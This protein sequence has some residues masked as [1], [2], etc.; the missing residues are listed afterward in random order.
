[1][2]SIPL[3]ELGDLVNETIEEM[4]QIAE[5]Y[6]LAVND[7]FVTVLNP[8]AVDEWK[9]LAK[10]VTDALNALKMLQAEIEIAGKAQ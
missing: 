4:G 5:D 9:R 6:R 10:P 1:M 7:L 8:A 3:N 2:A